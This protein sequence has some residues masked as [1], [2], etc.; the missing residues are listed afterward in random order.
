MHVLCMYIYV[1]VILLYTLAINQVTGVTLT[2]E[3]MKDLFD[4]YCTVMW[5][6]SVCTYVY[7]CAYTHT[8]NLCTCYYEISG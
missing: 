3:L 1:Y 5:S 2:C 6:V 7:T 4:Y 8:M